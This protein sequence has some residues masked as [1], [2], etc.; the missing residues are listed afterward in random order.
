MAVSINVNHTVTYT[1]QV[2]SNLT[3]T[4]L[5][6]Q[7]QSYAENTEN[8]TKENPLFSTPDTNRNVSFVLNEIGPGEPGYTNYEIAQ[9]F[10]IENAVA[11]VT[12]STQTDLTGVDKDNFLEG[13]ANNIEVVFFSERPTWVSL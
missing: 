2:A 7:F 9:T 3:G 1:E 4:E 10:T 11:T 13:V 8:G 12:T 5:E 6:A